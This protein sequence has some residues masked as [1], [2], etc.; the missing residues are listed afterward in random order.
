MPQSVAMRPPQATLK[1][2]RPPRGA[3]LPTHEQSA[4]SS[5]A[6]SPSLLDLARA[7]DPDGWRQLV[8]LYSPLVFSWCRRFGLSADDSADVMQDVWHSVTGAIGR[9][10]REQGGFRAWLYTVTRNKIH[11][12]FRK[13]SKRPALAEGGSA[14]HERLAEV[15]NAEPED[16]A[17]AGETV[18]LLHRALE[19]IRRDFEP[20]TWDA[21]WALAVEGRTATEV[22]TTFRTTPDAVYQAK[23]RVMRRLRETLGEQ[24]G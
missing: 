4:L 6:T 24:L 19:V 15:P 3:V 14:A 13:A 1:A 9:F 12:Y 22:A 2:P 17:S 8:Q 21:F 5:G 11:D 10:E 16:D 23:A 7:A 18:S 20:R